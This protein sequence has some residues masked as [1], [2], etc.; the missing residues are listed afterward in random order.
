MD[1]NTFTKKPKKFKQTYTRKLMAI[2][3]WGRK[4]VL[5][6]EVIQQEATITSE[7]YCETL[8]TKGVE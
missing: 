1:A 2:I 5:M 3:F 6:V 4:G 8:R 7:I